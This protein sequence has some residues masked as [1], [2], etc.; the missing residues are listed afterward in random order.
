MDQFLRRFRKAHP[1]RPPAAA[2]ARVPTP[3]TGHGSARFCGVSAVS[4]CCGCGDGSS[5]A[6]GAS[7]GAGEAVGSGVAVGTGEAVPLREAADLEEAAPAAGRVTGTG[8]GS[9]GNGGGVSA[10]L[11][12][13]VL[14]G[15][16]CG[17]ACRHQGLS[18]PVAGQLVGGRRLC[19]R[20]PADGVEGR[21]PVEGPV[22]RHFGG[23]GRLPVVRARLLPAH[24]SAGVGPEKFRC[25]GSLGHIL[26]GD[27]D[28]LPGSIRGQNGGSIRS[29][30]LSPD[31]SALAILQQ[32]GHQ[33]GGELRSGFS[34]R[35]V[36]LFRQIET[37]A[38]LHN[39]IIPDI[40]GTA[41]NAVGSIRSGE[42]AGVVA[43]GN[44]DGVRRNRTADT[45]GRAGPGDGAGVVTVF[46]DRTSLGR[47][48]DAAGGPGF[49]G[50]GTGAVAIFNRSAAAPGNG[51]HTIPGTA[52]KGPFGQP[53]IFYGAVRT[54][55]PEQA[56]LLSGGGKTPDRVS[57]PV[58]DAGVGI[59]SAVFLQSY[60]GPGPA[61]RDGD[62]GG[63]FCID[64]GTLPAGCQEFREP[65]QISGIF[66]LIRPVIQFGGL[67]SRSIRSESIVIIGAQQLDMDRTVS[68]NGI[69]LQ[70]VAILQV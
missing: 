59:A 16:A 51:A 50:D 64:F 6:A 21:V 23:A 12:Q 8:V 54:H 39:G 17:G 29:D 19:H 11:P 49:P 61:R 24:R 45:A 37:A 55:S 25:S 7:V 27:A 28:H 57:L 44:P 26:N 53:E 46:E 66:D 1:P 65:V 48:A 31:R 10:L 3:R 5:L 9:G 70:G 34:A 68:L 47:A 22:P 41:G 35:A 56:T 40:A 13:A 58:K 2:T 33:T 38:R 43:A 32:P 14:Q 20:R 18:L 62:V 52:G 42:G 67:V 69:I 63:Q 15:A 36:F 4:A 30:R 60:G